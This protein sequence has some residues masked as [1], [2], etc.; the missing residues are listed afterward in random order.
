MAP[1]WTRRRLLH[2]GGGIGLLGVAGCVGTSETDG[3]DVAEP[4]P[5]A[6]AQQFNAPG[7]GCCESYATYLRGNITGHLSETT[8]DELDAIKREYGIP[9]ELQSCHT[10]VL[11]EYVVEGHVPAGTI[12]TLIDERPAIDGIAL[13]GMPSGSPGMGGEKDGPFTIF[14]IGG[15]QTGSVFT[16]L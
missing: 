16:E 1:Q 15:R 14:A 10:L 9:G 2:F 8:P 6:E 12:G 7:C 13:P 11:D 5:I 3:W 4:L